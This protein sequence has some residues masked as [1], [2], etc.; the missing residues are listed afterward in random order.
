M[1]DPGIKEFNFPGCGWAEERLG[2]VKAELETKFYQGRIQLKQIRN[3]GK[4]RDG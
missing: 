1:K 3:R 2:K 4:S